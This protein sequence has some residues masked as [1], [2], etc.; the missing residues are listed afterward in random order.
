[1]DRH[2]TRENVRACANASLYAWP[3]AAQEIC[4]LGCSFSSHSTAKRIR[5]P[6][7]PKICLCV[8]VSSAAADACSTN[9]QPAASTAARTSGLHNNVAF[10]CSFTEQSFLDVHATVFIIN[11]ILLF[12]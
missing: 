3:L 1:M 11:K 12:V 8:T 7:S 6:H 2:I 10:S 5:P 9:G 4:S